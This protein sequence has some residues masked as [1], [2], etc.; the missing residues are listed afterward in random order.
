MVCPLKSKIILP[1]LALIAVVGLGACSAAPQPSEVAAPAVT[2]TSVPA[3]AIPQV[4][5]DPATSAATEPATTG[6]S[7]VTC[8]R[9]N[10]NQETEEQLMSTIPNFPNRMVREFFEYRPYVSIQQFRREI[11]KYVDANQ[12]AEWEQYV[13]VP[14]DPNQSDEET[15]MQIP[16]INAAVA[17]TLVSGRPYAST[18]AFLDALA[19]HVTPD[20][21]AGATCYLSQ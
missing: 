1:A 16:G 11:G 6:A 18:Q 17:A 13:Y 10:L 12:V 8:A 14:V 4:V 2:P 3:T 20:Q 21:L 7:A 5:E 15:L 19:T 9:L